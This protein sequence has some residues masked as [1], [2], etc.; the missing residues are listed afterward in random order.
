MESADMSAGGFG[1]GLTGLGTRPNTKKKC[2]DIIYFCDA[3]YKKPKVPVTGGVMNF[4]VSS[5]SLEDIS[6]VKATLAVLQVVLLPL[7]GLCV[8]EKC[9]FDSAKSFVLDIELS[10]VFGKTISDKVISVKRIFYHVDGFR[11]ASTPLKFPGIIRSSFTSESSLRKAK[12]LAINEKIMVN[13]NVR[14]VTVG[15]VFSKFGKIVSIKIQ[16]IGLWQKTLMEFESPEVASLVA[17]K[18]DQYR[19]L[20]YTLPVGITAHDLSDLLDS[21]G[22]KTCFIGRNLSSY[23]HNRC[24]VVCFAD[25]AFKLAAINSIPV[26]KGM[27]LWWT[28]L[29]LACC[30]KCEQ[31]GY[32][33]N[34]CSVGGNSGAC[35]KRMVTPQDRVCLANIYKK[36]QA[37]I[38]H[39]VSFGGKT[40]A[41]VAGGFFSYVVSSDPSGAGMSLGAKP[42]LLVSNSLGDSCLIKQLASLEHFLELLADQVSNILKKLSFM[43][44]VPLVSGLRASSMVVATPVAANI[45]SD[46]AIDDTAVSSLLPLLVV[47]NSVTDLSLSSSRVL[48]TKVGGLESK[49]VVLEVSVESVLEKLDCLCFGLGSS[50]SLTS[51]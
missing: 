5:L 38:I 49:M 2:V 9:N 34:V 11:R 36:K 6:I 13:N 40:W 25:K 16:L 33:S 47:V 21:Y 19:A 24:A 28:G 35:S 7:L 31:F 26:F 37:L 8:S 23:V 14:K 15:S 32:V 1:V 46:M 18:W 10:T 50:T 20:L 4:S 29:F 45:D 17:S 39:S 42:V 12:E 41:Q 51:Q 48:T 44:L 3:S 30:A 27:S 43:E 22:E